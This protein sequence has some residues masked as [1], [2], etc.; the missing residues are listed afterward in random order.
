MQKSTLLLLAVLLGYL[1]SIAQPTRLFKSW[2]VQQGLSHNFIREI[3]QD[4]DGYVWIATE[5]GLNQWNGYAFTTFPYINA[6][7]E[8]SLGY[9]I[10]A[11]AEDAVGNLWMGT[12]GGGV[13]IYNKKQNHFRQLPRQKTGRKA[14]SAVSSDFIYDLLAD[15][16]NN[17]WIGTA[18]A[19]VDK[20]NVSTGKTAHYG[21][22]SKPGMRLSSNKAISLAQD[23]QKNIWIATLGGGLNRL[24]SKTGQVRV[25]NHLS[26]DPQSLAD[27]KLYHVFVDQSDRLWV[28]TWAYGLER[29]DPNTETFTHFRHQPGN[30][31]SLPNDQVWALTQDSSGNLWVGTDNGL[32]LYE[33]SSQHFITYRNDPF[34]VNSLASGTIKC[35]YADTRGRVWIGTYNKGLSLYDPTYNQMGHY[36][37]TVQSNKVL[38][39]EISAFAQDAQGNLFI[40]SDGGGL[41]LYQKHKG[42]TLDLTRITSFTHEPAKSQSLASNKVKAL[43]VDRQ[44]RLWL[45]YWAGGLDCFD[46]KKN[47]I[48]HYDESTSGIASTLAQGRYLR[49]RNVVSLA[50]DSYGQIW[51][52][53]FGGGLQ[54]LD[55]AT[56]EFTFYEQELAVVGEHSNVWSVFA[57]SQSRVWVGGSDGHLTLFVPRSAGEFVLKET[58]QMTH[59]IYDIT[60]DAKGYIWI[61]T[62]GGGIQYLNREGKPVGRIAVAQ[63]L[64]SNVI[65]A[66][67]FDLR[68]NLWASTN[69]GIA[70]ISPEPNK[71]RVF[72]ETDGVQALQFNRQAAMRLRSGELL[73]GGTNGFNLFHPDSLAHS[74]EI[75]PLVFE[76]FALF[77]KQVPIGDK[78]SPLQQH[79]NYQDS[80]L[81]THQQSVITIGFAALCYSSPEKIHYQYRLKGFVDESWQQADQSRNV[82]Y[83]TLEPGAYLFEVTYQAE[84]VKSAPVR[85]LFIRILPPVWKTWWAQ[86][87]WLA[88]A[89]GLLWGLYLLRIRQ[90]RQ[91]NRLLEEQ[92]A[93]RTADLKRINTVLL[94]KNLVIQEQK[95]EIETQAEELTES[96]NQIRSINSTLEETVA[97][98][99]QDLRK[100]NQEL[101]NFVYRVSHDIRAPLASLSGLISLMEQE[102]NPTQLQAY[103]QMAIQSINRLD[104]FVKDILDYSRNARLEVANQLVDLPALVSTIWQELQY[105]EQANRI[106]L[107]TDYTLESALWTDPVRLRIMLQNLF[108]NAIKYHNRQAESSYLKINAHITAHK[109]E[110]ILADNG[111]GIG[112]EHLDKIFEMFYR[113]SS[114]SK[115]SGLGLYIVK[116]TV[117]K[118]KGSIRVE[119]AKGQGTQFRIA[120]PNA[121]GAFQNSRIETT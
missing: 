52:G 86:V 66:L 55:P 6:R 91:R 2:S 84:G 82:T 67:E 34:D 64:P 5:E 25:Y 54:R 12:W 48:I 113:A 79:I 62:E 40:G 97:E 109:A 8:Q 3:L 96:N 101:D 93:A 98:R 107:I 114:Q 29:F 58:K 92:V 105:M 63:G 74:N 21:T 39:N 75:F 42:I 41:S 61:A 95:E 57:D 17:I 32:A 89:T 19:G 73:F 81:L 94:E 37:K 30:P 100:T 111:L 103:Q 68:G 13:Y 118:L 9:P 65:Q 80:V 87:I 56:G 69:R 43:L 83:T 24:D 59:A 4:K 88:L 46:W 102:D 99:T 18:D 45:G 22:E 78:D 15:A 53:T 1:S 77:H 27:D 90:I 60:E 112:S 119:S 35:L 11:L 85:R 33:V 26:G 7:Q 117:E 49:S 110:I 50:E 106:E 104:G 120:L 51:I 14:A 47:Q 31:H 36:Y 44:N 38:H 70:R 72:N 121:P 23:H 20:Y 28:G 16:D 71:I 76:D 10:M 115:G 116:E 108:S